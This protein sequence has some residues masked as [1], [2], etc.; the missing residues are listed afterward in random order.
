MFVLA[1]KFLHFEYALMAL[2]KFHQMGC[3]FHYHFFGTCDL[4]LKFT[5][6]CHQIIGKLC[7]RYTILQLYGT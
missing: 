6:N 4:S 7:T 3:T 1:H 2:N 5:N